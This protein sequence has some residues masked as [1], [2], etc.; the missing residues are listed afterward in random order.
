MQLY[1]TD[2]APFPALADVPA[3]PPPVVA[4]GPGDRVAWL[5]RGRRGEDGGD[6]GVDWG[7]HAGAAMIYF[8]R[9]CCA[10]CAATRGRRECSAAVRG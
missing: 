3:S 10:A 7:R 6:A 4:S 5:L 2:A 9:W 1:S 8:A